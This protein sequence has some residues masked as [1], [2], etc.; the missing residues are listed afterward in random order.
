MPV[1][2][3]FL[4]IFFSALLL[5]AS[6]A[7]S[8]GGSAPSGEGVS[9]RC[10]AA[11]DKAA[12]N[13]SRCL[14]QAEARFAKGGDEEAKEA[15]Q[16]RCGERFDRA[17]ARAMSLFGADQ[18]TPAS[19]MSAMADRTVSYAAQVASEAGGTA[20]LDDATATASACTP[21]YNCLVAGFCAQ[22]AIYYPPNE[23]GYT[24]VYAGDTP[25]MQPALGAGCNGGVGSDE[26]V[27]GSSLP[28]PPSSS[29]GSFPLSGFMRK[30]CSSD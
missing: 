17:S 29:S 8:A 16:G 4:L 26:W 21:N 13:Y 3:S 28:V 25:S 23:Y 24:N 2:F 9:P 5:M 1:R 10:E 6:P 15:A 19:L 27:A 22:A 18:C 7:F 11:I 30:L 12:G 14:L 20:A